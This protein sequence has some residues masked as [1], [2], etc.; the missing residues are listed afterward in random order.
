MPQIVSSRKNGNQQ[1]MKQPI[2]TPSTFVAFRSRLISILRRTSPG[3]LLT[4][5]VLFRYEWM[6]FVSVTSVAEGIGLN[7]GVSTVYE[8]LG[9][10]GSE[11]KMGLLTV[12]IGVGKS[13]FFTGRNSCWLTLYAALKRLVVDN[14]TTG[15]VT[16]TKVP[17]SLFRREYEL[18]FN[19]S[20]CWSWVCWS[21]LDE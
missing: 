14:C 3:D 2:T 15:R 20:N 5:V 10:D 16:V 7:N 1:R 6:L 9:D 18:F 8:V 12:W 17:F 4:T 21:W 19:G 13:L 11:F